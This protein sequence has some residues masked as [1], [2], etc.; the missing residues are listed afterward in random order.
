MDWYSLRPSSSI[1]VCYFTLANP[2]H[3]AVYIPLLLLCF[4]LFLFFLVLY[5]GFPSPCYARTCL[6]LSFVY[7][8]SIHIGTHVGLCWWDGMVSFCT[9]SVPMPRAI[10]VY[11]CH[12]EIMLLDFLKLWSSSP[13]ASIL[14]QLPIWAITMYSQCLPPP[15]NINTRAESTSPILSIMNTIVSSITTSQ[16]QKVNSSSFHI[17]TNNLSWT[18]SPIPTIFNSAIHTTATSTPWDCFWSNWPQRL[19]KKLMGFLTNWSSP[20]SPSWTID[21][22]TSTR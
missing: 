20:N 13:V 2:A 22:W 4:C 3:Y 8:M 10:Y 14:N 9:V 15:V 16:S 5:S 7:L 18:T 21:N 17:W 12:G 19:T 11:M 1:S 6:H